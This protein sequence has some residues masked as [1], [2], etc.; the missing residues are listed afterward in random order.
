VK[1][2][3]PSIDGGK[4]PFTPASKDVAWGQGPLHPASGN[5]TRGRLR[6]PALDRAVSDVVKYFQG[7]NSYEM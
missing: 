4:G 1:G 5:V 3:L 7:S 2:P 6:P